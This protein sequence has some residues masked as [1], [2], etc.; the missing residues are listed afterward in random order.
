LEPACIFISEVTTER[1]VRKSIDLGAMYHIYKP[2]DLE[3]LVM[4]IRQIL[5]RPTM[6]DE[7]KEALL[8]DNKI[9]R[10]ESKMSDLLYGIG[11]PVNLVGYYYIR[12]ALMIAVNDI[13]AIKSKKIKIYETIAKR[14]DTTPQRVERGI[15]QAILSTFRRGARNEKLHEL[16]DTGI[17]KRRR[18]GKS[19]FI[20]VISDK[21]RFEL[22]IEN[23]KTLQSN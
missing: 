12:E 17:D 7:K 16:F 23:N 19:E 8:R 2:F 13:G 11:V 20:A 22:E 21:L 18:P 1:I 4:R 10:L 6:T 9:L 15:Y 3:I 5:R 14:W